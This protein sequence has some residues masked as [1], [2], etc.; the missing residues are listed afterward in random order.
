MELGSKAEK[1]ASGETSIREEE[2]W[3]G[4]L[5]PEFVSGSGRISLFLGLLLYCWTGCYFESIGTRSVR[6][7]IAVLERDEEELLLRDRELE[8]DL[9]RELELSRDCRES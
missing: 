5:N 1:E 9:E 6:I 4:R 3:G 8:R 2:V 7:I